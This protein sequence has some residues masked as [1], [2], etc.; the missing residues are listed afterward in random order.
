[1]ITGPTIPTNQGMATLPGIYSVDRHVRKPA[2]TVA[3][4]LRN[5]RP[6]VSTHRPKPRSSHLTA[7]GPEVYVDGIESVTSTGTSRLAVARRRS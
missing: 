4:S 7:H 6:E 1:M 5:E 2:D 3:A